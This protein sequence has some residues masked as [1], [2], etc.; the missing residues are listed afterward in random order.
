MPRRQKRPKSASAYRRRGPVREPYDVVL[1]V[2]EGR[3]MEPNY[4]NGLKLAHRLSNMNLKIH[5]PPSG[6]DPMSPVNFAIQELDR[7]KECDRGYCVFD[8]DDHAGF[9]EAVRTIQTSRH[10]Q[11]SRLFAI[12]SVP[13]FEIW[14]LLHYRYSSAP[15]VASGGRSAC[16]HLKREIRAHYP[17]YTEG[18]ES[19]FADL[20]FHLDRALRHAIQ[21]EQH[22]SVSG[23]CNPST[24]MHHLVDYLVKLKT[25]QW[26]QP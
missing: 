3:K 18:S 11:A 20:A 7:D 21:L 9:E 13:C 5:H 22:N 4:F 25:V 6:H 17:T 14:L 15:Y 2:C 16:D 1:I 26:F 19:I 12:T 23:A 10:A 8:R 24:K